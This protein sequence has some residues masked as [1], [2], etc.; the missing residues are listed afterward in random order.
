MGGGDL[1][2]DTSGIVSYYSVPARV[3]GVDLSD[4]ISFCTINGVV[5]ARVGGV[6]LSID[7]PP[8]LDDDGS[9]RPCGRG[10]FKLAVPVKVEQELWSPP[11][12]AGWI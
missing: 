7:E 1:S 2:S 4:G 12:W 6:D 10:G 3:G 8:F 11:V 9:P 5:P